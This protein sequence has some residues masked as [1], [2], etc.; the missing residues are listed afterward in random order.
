MFIG[1]RKDS[2][3]HIHFGHALTDPSQTIDSRILGADYSQCRYKG[4]PDLAGRSQQIFTV[5]Q[6]RCCGSFQF[7][8]WCIIMKTKHHDGLHQTDQRQTYH[9]TKWYIAFRIFHIPGYRNDIFCSNK[10][11]ECYGHHGYNFFPA[12][13]HTVW[14]L[15]HRTGSQS[16]HSDN[17]H[18]QHGTHQQKCHQILDLCKHIHTVQIRNHHHNGHNQ[19]I[20]NTGNR[21]MDRGC[22]RIR[23]NR[24]FYTR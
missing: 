21:Q 13:N 24:S 17:S 4:H 7:A 18:N 3:H 9:H 19:C 14:L 5:Q 2:W 23:E 16:K 6:V 8:P 1:L 20:Q 15:H 22:H 12:A 11:P 10:K